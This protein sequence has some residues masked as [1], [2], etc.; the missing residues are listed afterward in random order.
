MILSVE[1][2]DQ[3][4]LPVNISDAFLNHHWEKGKD[5][6]AYFIITCERKE[7]SYI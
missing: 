2:L 6:L 4:S 3:E 5:R 7:H 1:R